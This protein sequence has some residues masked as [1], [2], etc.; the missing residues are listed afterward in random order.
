MAAKINWHIDIE[1]NDVTVTLC[2]TWKSLSER[3]VVCTVQMANALSTFDNDGGGT[4]EADVNEN[5][6]PPPP[7]DADK[8]WWTVHTSP[9][10]TDDSRF[11]PGSVHTNRVHG[12]C[13][14]TCRRATL[15]LFTGLIRGLSTRPVNVG[16]ILDTRV[17]SRPRVHAM[18][19][20][21][22]YVLLD[23]K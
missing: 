22:F 21:R 16:V 6:M 12:P 11:R 20:A 13:W 23:T 19:W 18:N 2:I 10:L 17:N 14:N 7:P 8:L 4:T 9:R 3:D 1:Q 15:Y 5:D